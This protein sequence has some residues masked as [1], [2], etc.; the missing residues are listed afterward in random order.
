[1]TFYRDYCLECNC[2][3]WVE[4]TEA[5]RQVCHGQNYFPRETA[6]HYTRWNAGGIELR[7]KA[8][9]TPAALPLDFQFMQELANQDW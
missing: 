2:V 3:H 4:V 1:M 9:A 5:R 7:E 6:T 8:S